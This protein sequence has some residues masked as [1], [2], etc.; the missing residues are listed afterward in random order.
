MQVLATFL[1][2]VGALIYVVGAIWLLVAIFRES[3][4]WGLGSLLVPLA[5]LIFVILHW[6]AAK[7]PL[8]V[9]LIGLAIGVFGVA[10]DPT[11]GKGSTAQPASVSDPTESPSAATEEPSAGAQAPAGYRTFEASGCQLSA[12][13]TWSIPS[14]AGDDGAKIV[15]A[16]PTEKLSVGIHY[17]SATGLALTQADVARLMA[18]ANRMPL[19]LED[20][21]WSMVDKHDAW[22]E[23]RSGSMGGTSRVWIRYSYQ[24]GSV[25]VQVI[26]TA[27]GNTSRQQREILEK[28]I[29]SAHCEP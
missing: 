27:A 28:I 12:P 6:D 29:R 16:D 23:V 18:T 26:G 9:G 5:A 15:V 22:R 11:R 19:K 10:V 17:E 4:L 20:S 7:R 1:I 13:A 2:V 25:V 8:V 24:L 14:A 3:I 21:H